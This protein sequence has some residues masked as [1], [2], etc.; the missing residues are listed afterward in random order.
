MFVI[1]QAKLTFKHFDKNKRK[2]IE[3]LCNVTLF[4][5]VVLSYKTAGQ[6]CNQDT[7]ID[8]ICSSYSGFL[9]FYLFSYM[10]YRKA[11]NL[12]AR[13]WRN[14]INAFRQGLYLASSTLR[15]CLGVS[16]ARWLICPPLAQQL[17]WPRG[18]LLSR[19]QPVAQ[20]WA[21]WPGLTWIFAVGFSSRVVGSWRTQ[22]LKEPMRCDGTFTGVSENDF[23]SLPLN[24][25]LEAHSLQPLLTF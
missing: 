19:S 21:V 8:G 2:N 16:K 7:D 18:S 6:Y 13:R 24:L 17:C 1:P 12:G 11:T 25:N 3:I 14:H 22:H 15:S 4:P 23:S 5:P 20:G 10:L 9:S